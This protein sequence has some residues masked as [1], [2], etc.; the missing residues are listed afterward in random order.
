MG[1]STKMREKET[2]GRDGDNVLIP[3]WY[4]EP[5]W[6]LNEMPQVPLTFY[7]DQLKMMKS[8]GQIVQ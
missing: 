4:W 2:N 6:L 3:G 1:L 5:G 8:C 7:R